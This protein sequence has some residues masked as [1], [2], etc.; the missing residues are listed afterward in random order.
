MINV[1]RV[2]WIGQI[3]LTYPVIEMHSQFTGS[4]FFTLVDLIKAVHCPTKICV[5]RCWRLLVGAISLLSWKARGSQVSRLA[6]VAFAPFSP[7]ARLTLTFYFSFHS[8]FCSF[9]H[10]LPTPFQHSVWLVLG[11]PR[12][13]GLATNVCRNCVDLRCWVKL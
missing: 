13:W 12:T 10:R 7:L 2:F 9:H 3:R 11:E 5:T 8:L 4:A 6:P 1:E